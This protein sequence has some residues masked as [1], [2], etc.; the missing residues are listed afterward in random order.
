MISRGKKSDEQDRIEKVKEMKVYSWTLEEYQDAAKYDL[1]YMS[2]AEAMGTSLGK[3]KQT[4]R[5]ETEEERR[6][7]EVES[8]YRVAGGSCRLMFEYTTE[9]AIESLRDAMSDVDDFPS[10]MEFSTG[11]QSKRFVNLLHG[12]HRIGKKVYW[13]LVSR[14]A[15]TELAEKLGESFVRKIQE[16]T[17]MAENPVLR[18]VLFEMLFFARI[19]QMPG[20]LK[21][22]TIQGGDVEWSRCEVESFDPTDVYEA[23]ENSKERVCLKPVAWNQGGYDAVIVDWSSKLVRFV[24]VTSREAHDLKLRYFSDCLDSLSIEGWEQWKLEIVFVVPKDNV[25]R[26]RVSK[27]E[28]EDA[29]SRYGWRGGEEGS[30]VCVVGLDPRPCG[31][32]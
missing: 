15:A 22:T 5:R 31:C 13:G 4:R 29:L 14:F 1:L 24:Q 11:E 2:V 3:R 9:E 19:K 28:D 25:E 30:E 12:K 10:L 18:G 27:V 6:T 23:G 32:L 17:N 20:P 16:L 26:F 7:R 21:L 8:K